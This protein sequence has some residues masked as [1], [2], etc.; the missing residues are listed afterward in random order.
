M[1]L[2]LF[3]SS[4]VDAVVSSVVD[5]VVSSVVD[6]VVSRLDGG[7][8]DDELTQEGTQDNDAFSDGIFGDVE[9]TKVGPMEGFRFV[10]KVTTIAGEKS[11]WVDVDPF[12]EGQ[13]FAAPILIDVL[14]VSLVVDDNY[15]RDD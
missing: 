8:T 15:P 9:L 10:N 12:G 7:K 4:V 6:A 11:E 3:T 14:D 1:Y 2:Y 13:M 5:A